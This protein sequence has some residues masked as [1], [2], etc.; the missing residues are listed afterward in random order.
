MATVEVYTIIVKHE[1]HAEKV[2][3]RVRKGELQKT[4]SLVTLAF[5]RDILNRKMEGVAM[6]G[7]YT[8]E[9][10]VTD[11]ELEYK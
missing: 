8:V 2:T 5:I 9:W 10:E 11:M 6:L 3:A 7:G 1:N 4:S